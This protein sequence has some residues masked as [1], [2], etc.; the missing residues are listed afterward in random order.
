MSSH[1]LSAGVVVVHFRANGCRYLLLRAYR[2]WDFPKGLVEPGKDPMEAACR[3]AREEAG[4]VRLGFRWGPIFLE[5]PPYGRGKI[6]RYYVAESEQVEIHL[7]TS[8]ELGR[9]EH[10]E[11]RWLGYDHAR[12]LLVPRVAAILDW[13]H[14][15][16]GCNGDA[17]E[18]E[19]AG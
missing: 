3:E 14:A 8:P 13:A 5:T 17:D 10:H 18:G 9:P 2:Y 6:A 4:L 16:T 1:V 12:G 19:R 11:C 7:P 15:V